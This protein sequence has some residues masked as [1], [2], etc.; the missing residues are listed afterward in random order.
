MR[1]L[2]TAAFLGTSIIV[3]FLGIAKRAAAVTTVHRRMHWTACK[4]P[5]AGLQLVD[6]NGYQATEG[7]ATCNFDSVYCPMLTDDT[8]KNTSINS[9]S[10]SG[11]DASTTLEFHGK[12]CVAFAAGGGTGGACGNPSS[13]GTSF[14]GSWS[15]SL[16][17]TAFH[18]ASD[19]DFTFVRVDVP[20]HA[21]G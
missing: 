6:V 8:L 16:D 13:S 18:N 11:Y 9:L 2:L 4:D 10:L 1:R 14:T 15:P 19:D 7:D 3:L 12:G 21:G 20:C 17:V 5:L